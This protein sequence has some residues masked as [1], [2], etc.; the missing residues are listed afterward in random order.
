MSL[1]RCHFWFAIRVRRSCPHTQVKL[2]NLRFARPSNFSDFER[3]SQELRM[4]FL[5]FVIIVA[6]APFPPITT[7]LDKH[8]SAA[9]RQRILFV[10][11]PYLERGLVL[12][13][14]W[15]AEQIFT[16]HSSHR[17]PWK[18]VPEL[19]AR[20][21]K[22]DARRLP[23][24]GARGRTPAP[25]YPGEWGHTDPRHGG[26]RG[27]GSGRR[28]RGDPGSDVPPDPLDSPDLDTWTFS[29]GLTLFA[30][31]NLSGAS[32]S[33]VPPDPFD[34]PDVAYVQPHPSTG[35]TS[36]AS[37]PLGA[38]GLLFLVPPPLGKVCSSVPHMPISRASSSNSDEHADEPMDEVTPVQQ[39][40]M[41]NNDEMRYPWTIRPDISNEGIHMVSDESSM[42]CP[43]VEE[44]DDDN[45][46]TDEIM[47]LGSGEQIDDLIEPGTTR[48][49]DWNDAM[50]DIQ[51][52]MRFTKE[53][54]YLIQVYQNK[55][56]NITSKF[57]SKLISHL[58]ANDPKIPVSNVI[59]EVQVLLQTGY[60]YKRAW[61]ARKFAIKRVFG[62]WETT[63]SILPKYLQAM[64][65]SNPR[66]V[67]EFLHHR[68][69]SFS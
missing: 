63:F 45:K 11:L 47:T 69:S 18:L 2:S 68:T 17:H 3:R 41:N 13:D 6:E 39:H 53:H 66:T 49:L 57:I 7:T 65:D 29:L 35:G 23:Y 37:P 34:S 31:S 4:Y 38:V 27:G 54:T 62:S 59:Q 58:V 26:E 32:T 21:V 25:P 50:I 5:V 14:L 33:Y 12:F 48:L 56:R 52:S 42:L 16:V 15:W 51:L 36:Y 40:S 64:K 19:D 55:H 60:T 46:D 20:R 8:S 28:G 10:W 43:D 30:P 67:Y 61:Y 44:D 1:K 9:Q 22:K 24:G